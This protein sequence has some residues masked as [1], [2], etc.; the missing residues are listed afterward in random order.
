MYFPGKWLQ[1]PLWKARSNISLACGIIRELVGSHRTNSL[2]N[3]YALKSFTLYQVDLTSKHHSEW[4]N[5]ESTFQSTNKN[6]NKK[7]FLLK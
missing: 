4:A 1:V 5:I 6:K 7:Q 3:F 2:E